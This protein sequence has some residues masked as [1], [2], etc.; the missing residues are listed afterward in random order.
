MTHFKKL[1]SLLICFALLLTLAVSAFGEPIL[2][3]QVLDPTRIGTLK[4]ELKNT[5]GNPVS[6]GTLLMVPV[7]QAIHDP[8]TGDYW[9]YLPPFDTMPEAPAL[10]N[11][12]F[13]AAF[14][15][16]DGNHEYASAFADWMK[17]N[18]AESVEAEIG[19]D[20]V[21]QTEL[22]VLGLYL[23]MQG[24]RTPNYYPIRPFLVTVPNREEG[25]LVY[26]VDA[27]PKTEPVHYE[28]KP[29][30]TPSDEPT[31]TPVP[32]QGFLPQTGQLNWP[33]PV[34]ALSGMALFLLGWWLS[35][36]ERKRD[37]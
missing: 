8:Y 4:V 5:M 29:T 3:E 12:G 19:A 35:S 15:L 37:K 33:V 28:P 21:A 25:V 10:D 1:F 23:V 9:E 31:P 24:R 2:P 32:P 20:G 6:G 17:E 26:D 11:D 16:G 36:S 27:S 7:A 34:L 18:P 30:P 22:P 13:E 14:N